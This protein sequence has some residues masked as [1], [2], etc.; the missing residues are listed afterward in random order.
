V[1]KL[2]KKKARERG[3]NSNQKKKGFRCTGDQELRMKVKQTSFTAEHIYEMEFPKK[4]KRHT[5]ILGKK[6][7]GSTLL[8][9]LAPRKIPKKKK[10]T[11]LCGGYNKLLHATVPRG[12]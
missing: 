5:S 3:T 4:P 7:K 12:S 6:R 8:G 11:R 10:N 2:T 1:G 9:A